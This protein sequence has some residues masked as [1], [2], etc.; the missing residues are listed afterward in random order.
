MKAV[1][2]HADAPRA[3]TPRTYTIGFQTRFS[4]FSYKDLIIGLKENLNS[5][6]I[7]LIHLT[8]DGFPGYGDLNFFYPGNPDEIIYNREVCF[9]EFLKNQ[10]EAHEQYWFTEADVRLRNPFP[11]LE[12]GVDAALIVAPSEKRFL[13][14]W[15]LAKK[16]AAPIFEEAVA[17]FGSLKHWDG[18]TE[19]WG[20]VYL[21][22]GSP[23]ENQQITHNGMCLE[24]RAYKLY[25]MGKSHYT[26]HYKSK[27]KEFILKNNHLFINPEYKK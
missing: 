6:G 3:N 11:L 14:T 21:T 2:Y 10:A 1:I 9:T 13:P 27:H 12:Q 17:E 26:A 16:S 24:T 18:D 25:N 7:E 15:R 20:K 8:L 5:Y 19:A 22:A 23:G 4:H